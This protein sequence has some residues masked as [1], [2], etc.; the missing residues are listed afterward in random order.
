LPPLI[1]RRVLFGNP[2]KTAP[3]LAPDG[4][5]LAYLA[6]SPQGVSNVWVQT[7]GKKDDRM[8]TRDKHR[9]IY[10]YEWAA[11][12]RHILF[13]QDSDGDENWHIFSVD[14]DTGLVRDLT[15]FQGIRAQNLLTSPRRPGEILVGLNLRDRRVADMYRID[16]NSG[17]VIREAK[18]PGDVL[19][20]ETD[21]D[22]RIRA[23][24]AFDAG[25]ARTTVRVRDSLG[26]PWRDLLT[27][28]FE[29][30]NFYGQVNGGS[31]VAGFAPGG[32]SLWVVHAGDGDKTRLVEIDVK[33][34]RQ[35]RVLAS[36]PRSDVEY[37]IGAAAMRPMVLTD[38]KTG[39]LEAIAF[40]H[41]RL[42]WKPVGSALR[43]DLAALSRVHPGN[44]RVTSRVRGDTLWLVDFTS[45][46][47]PGSYFLYDRRSKKAEL[48]F[49]SRPEL[50][51]YKLAPC[52]PVVIKSRDGLD[53]V[54]YLTLPVGVSRKDLPLLLFPHGGPWWRDRWE[55]DPWVQLVANRGYAVL[56]VE[57][58][59]STGFGLR[60]LNAA[61]RQFGDQA[62]LRDLLDAVKWAT[63]DGLAN[64]RRIGAMGGSGGG[65]LTLC[66][67]AFHPELFACGVDLVGPSSVRTLLEAI[68]AYWKP[69]KKRW[70]L[71]LGDAEHDAELNRQ[72][73][74]LYHSDRMR[75]P[76]LIGH[77]L[78][79]PRVHIGEAERIV[80]ALRKRNR[81]VTLVVYPD[82]GHGFARPEN[83]LDFFGR[84]EE[85]LAQ[86]LGG[87]KEPWKKIPGSTA[88]VR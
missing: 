7:L 74:P 70:V 76:L 83:N 64:P 13:A 33:T 54:C 3:Q 61:S 77:G 87:R 19:S 62:V 69:V 48:L 85:F 59:G 30:C 1:P 14:I 17:A 47:D 38:P 82:E 32:K 21:D 56:Q 27:I 63:G 2:V 51:K 10:S 66:C 58:R 35:T 71:R 26:G 23:A 68:P 41:T 53:L 29:R 45:P 67:L 40:N 28:P 36:D 88:E 31:V 5:R 22:F 9:G 49:A 84:M 18:N 24:T 73:S 75:A 4:K 11:D 42:K 44:L 55:F 37:V 39:G 52:E 43:A 81:P 86:H 15:P 50:A 65:Y 57:Y 8:V 16:L 25:T 34:G 20:W 60:F 6:N 78:N 80:K 12:G 46:T 79:D 72:I